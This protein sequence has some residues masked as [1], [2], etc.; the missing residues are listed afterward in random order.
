MDRGIPRGS[1]T[2]MVQIDRGLLP[3]ARP[4]R[5][6]QLEQKLL[7]ALPWCAQGRV[8][9]LAHE[10]NSMCCQGHLASTRT[11]HARRQ[12]SLIQRLKEL[13]EMNLT[14]KT[15]LS[16]WS[17]QGKY[18]RL[19]DDIRLPNQKTRAKVNFLFP[20]HRQK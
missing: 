9:L 12:F 19:D 18:P 10:Q 8:N 15:L 20:T 3:V 17:G 1:I 5:L 6:S 7:G 2:E 11:L 4:R 14:D 16:N 13:H